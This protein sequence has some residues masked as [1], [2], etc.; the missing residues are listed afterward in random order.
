MKLY[1]DTEEELQ[2]LRDRT[3]RCKAIVMEQMGK[4]PLT[5]P[6][7][8]NARERQRFDALLTKQFGQ[9]DEDIL[10]EFNSIV[11]DVLFAPGQDIS[12]YPVYDPK[13]QQTE[14]AATAQDTLKIPTE[15]DKNSTDSC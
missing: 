13:P 9:S 2:Q 6:R 4:H 8:L 15:L 7:R 3:L 14:T 12:Q 5:N 10:A 11:A 1:V